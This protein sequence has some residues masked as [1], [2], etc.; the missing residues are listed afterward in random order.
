MD[1]LTAAIRAEDRDAFDHRRRHPVGAR[2]AQREA[3]LLLAGS[4]SA[5]WISSASTS[6]RRRAKWT[7]RSTA[8]AVYDIGKPL[9]IEETFPLACSA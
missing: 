1:K 9:V 8:M 6:I 5:R 4:Q 7:K 2:L 3:G